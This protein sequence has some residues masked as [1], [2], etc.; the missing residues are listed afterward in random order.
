MTIH[1]PLPVEHVQIYQYLCI[2]RCSCGWKYECYADTYGDA[3][4]G[5]KHGII[6][7]RRVIGADEQ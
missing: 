1:D 7:H 5:A 3:E 4:S 6:E 2:G